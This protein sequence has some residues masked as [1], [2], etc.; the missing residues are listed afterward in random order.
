MPSSAQGPPA[1]SRFFLDA[2]AGV[3]APLSQAASKAG[4]DR[5]EPLDIITNPAHDILIDSAFESL[6]RLC[7]SGAIGLTVCA[8]PCKE[9][10]RLKM[11]PG[12]PPALRTPAYM[13]GVPGLSPAQ[14]KKVR[15]SREIHRRGRALLH[16]VMCKGGV[17]VLEQ[18]P[19]SLA[20]LETANFDLF[21]EFQGHLAWVDACRHGKDWAKSWCFASNSAR[22]GRLAALCNH[23]IAHQSIAGV[24][25]ASGEYLSTTTAEYPAPLAKEIIDSVS[26]RVTRHSNGPQGRKL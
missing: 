3:H 23:N 2:F 5:Y 19:S 1:P 13:D 18:P 24:K 16:A 26:Y 7:W 22:I 9:Y 4:L 12:G 14:L 25:D 11:R 6:L 20:W 21:K 15:D 8:P 17:G 10:S